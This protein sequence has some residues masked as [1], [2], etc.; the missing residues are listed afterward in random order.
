[1]RFLALDQKYYSLGSHYNE[2]DLGLNKKQNGLMEDV[3]V[4]GELSDNERERSSVN[5]DPTDLNIQLRTQAASGHPPSATTRPSSKSVS[6]SNGVSTSSQ[7]IFSAVSS[8][9]RPTTR[10]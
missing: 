5:E 4:N 1:M 9:S 3:N 6:R 2:E 10:L 7:F 8:T